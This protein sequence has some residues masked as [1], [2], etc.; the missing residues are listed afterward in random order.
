MAVMV[1]TGCIWGQHCR[2]LPVNTGNVIPLFVVQSV[3][4]D[5]AVRLL[6]ELLHVDHEVHRLVVV[7]DYNALHWCTSYMERVNAHTE[8]EVEVEYLALVSPF[9]FPLVVSHTL[10]CSNSGSL[11]CSTA[12]RYCHI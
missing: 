3:P 7:D 12:L 2:A 5:A 1:D 6:H 10:S 11:I 8:R 4:V 9:G